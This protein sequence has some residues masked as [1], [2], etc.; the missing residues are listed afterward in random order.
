MLSSLTG[1]P[2]VVSFLLEPVE[3]GGGRRDSSSLVCWLQDLGLAEYVL[4]R[5]STEFVFYKVHL[6]SPWRSFQQDN[7]FGDLTI[8]VVGTEQTSV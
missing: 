2:F 6:P 4:E 5:T 7:L 1:A 8:V 3:N